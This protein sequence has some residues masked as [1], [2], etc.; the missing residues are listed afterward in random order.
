[1]QAVYALP[2]LPSTSTVVLPPSTFTVASQ[3]SPLRVIA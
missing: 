1:M 3:P 2:K